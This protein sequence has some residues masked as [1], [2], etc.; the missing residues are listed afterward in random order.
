[1][2]VSV[3]EARAIRAWFDSDNLWVSLT[4][5]RQLSVPLTFFPR[6]LGATQQQRENYLISG[7]GAGLHWESLDEDISVEGLLLGVGERTRPRDFA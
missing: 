6:L 3:L 7:G 2:S 5:G 4:D 1:M